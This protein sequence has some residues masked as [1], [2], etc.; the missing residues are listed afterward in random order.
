MPLEEPKPY[1]LMM[2]MMMRKRRKNYFSLLHSVEAGS[3][4]HPTS[5]SMDMG[6]SSPG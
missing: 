2:M 1:I 6:A 3:G 4:S 5:N